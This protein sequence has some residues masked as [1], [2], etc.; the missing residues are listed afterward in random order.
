MSSSESNEWYL[1]LPY[2]EA[3]RVA[4]N[5][6]IDVDPASNLQAQQT[7]RATVFYTIEDDGLT[8]DWP[9]TVLLNP[10][11][12]GL[13]ATF[14]A[15]LLDQY[16]RG[17]TTAAVLVV[18]TQAANAV[19]FRPLWDH[20]LCFPG[21]RVE[22]E[23]PAERQKNNTGGTVFVYLGPAPARFGAAFAPFGAIV[24]RWPS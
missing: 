16:A 5:G 13:Q 11:Y 20:T 6:T 23:S 21:H 14:T 15:H 19:W 4:L 12:G 2:V 8:H 7:V 22:F 10:P 18:R 24:R 3:S 1:P 9:G 17:I